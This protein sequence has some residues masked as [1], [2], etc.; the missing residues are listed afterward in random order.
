M[1]DFEIRIE[2]DGRTRPV[3]LARSN[4]VRGTETVL[5]EYAAE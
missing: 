1:A 5:F 3:G 2:L 4:R